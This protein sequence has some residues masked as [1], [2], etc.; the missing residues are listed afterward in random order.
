MGMARDFMHWLGRRAGLGPTGRQIRAI[1]DV[2]S[3]GNYFNATGD[4]RGLVAVADGA[5]SEQFLRNPTDAAD[6]FPS[7]TRFKND[8]EMIVDGELARKVMMVGCY[9]WPTSPIMSSSLAVSQQ[10]HKLAL[11]SYLLAADGIARFS[12]RH[13]NPSF[14]MPITASVRASGS[15]I[16]TLTLSSANVALLTAGQRVRVKGSGVGG[17]NGTW[18]ITAKPSATTIQ[19]QTANT[20]ALTGSAPFGSITY[21]GDTAPGTIPHVGMFGPHRQFTEHYYGLTDLWM[22]RVNLGVPTQ[23]AKDPAWTQAT[24]K[25]NRAHMNTLA[26]GGQAD[27]Y[28]RNFETGVVLVNMSTAVR[29]VAIPAGTYTD[30]DGSQVVSDGTTPIAIDPVSALAGDA[31]KR[32][33]RVLSL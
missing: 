23:W 21:V 22:R 4:E 27:L 30:V 5:M 16:A 15:N 18:T 20:T 24:G 25:T 12:F 13:D 31:T 28:R 7:V 1:A 2:S 10:W 9:L 8:C 14:L 11:A 32:N 33:A 17:F 26:V 29:S 3:G 19:V 6:A